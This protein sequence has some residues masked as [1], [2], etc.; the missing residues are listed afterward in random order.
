[1]NTLMKFSELNSFVQNNNV[2]GVNKADAYKKGEIIKTKVVKG[3]ENTLNAQSFKLDGKPVSM[4]YLNTEV[5]DRVKFSIG[6]GVT[7][8]PSQAVEVIVSL[9]GTG[10]KQ[11]Q[12]L[13][14][15]E[16]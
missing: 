13:P 12:I 14:K 6:A 3:V 9:S 5:S 15:K 7:Y 2:L 1:M 10:K 8:K 4:V 16:E 11:F